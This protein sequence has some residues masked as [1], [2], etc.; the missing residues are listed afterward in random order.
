VTEFLGNRRKT[1]QKGREITHSTCKNIIFCH[2][3]SNPE[4]FIFS[5]IELIGGFPL[6]GGK[7]TSLICPTVKNPR[8]LNSRTIGITMMKRELDA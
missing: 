8:A 3:R 2:F 5:K 7:I 6:K 4:V 1:G